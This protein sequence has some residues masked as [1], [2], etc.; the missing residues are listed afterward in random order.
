MASYEHAVYGAMSSLL[1]PASLPTHQ[2]DTPVLPHPSR[3][4]PNANDP[5]YPQVNDI[6]NDLKV[7]IAK[8]RAVDNIGEFP[9]FRCMMYT[10]LQCQGD[11]GAIKNELECPVCYEQYNLTNKEPIINT[12]GHTAC[13][14]CYMRMYVCCKCRTS[15]FSI[16]DPIIN[17]K[18][19]D[20]VEKMTPA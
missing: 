12:C 9:W 18:L 1:T 14:E 10:L 2:N 4:P 7:V 11:T 20:I 19:R 13:K 6:T 3:T 16:Y 5:R 17:Y 8:V 15:R